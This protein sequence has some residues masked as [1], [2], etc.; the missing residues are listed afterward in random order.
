MRNVGKGVYHAGAGGIE[1]PGDFGW[2]IDM[3]REQI[4]GIW[5]DKCAQVYFVQH[6]PK[7]GVCMIK[8][9]RAAP[10]Q[11]TATWQWDGNFD[12]PTITPSIG[13]DAAPRCGAHRTITGGLTHNGE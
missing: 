13:C 1:K 8:V 6:C 3:D 12:A 7:F 10:D 11:S 5:T 9:H 2:R 4:D